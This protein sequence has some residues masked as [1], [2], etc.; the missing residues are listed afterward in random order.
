MRCSHQ[1]LRVMLPFAIGLAVVVTVVATG[2]QAEPQ[3]ER[4]PIRENTRRAP[5]VQA[6]PR[7]ER[8]PINAPQVQI[9]RDVVYATIEQDGGEPIQLTMDVAFPADHGNEPLPVVVLIHGGGFSHGSKRNFDELLQPLARGGY[10]AATIDYR[11][12]GVAPYP[13][14]VHDC[15]AA[16]RFIRDN[17][18]D[19]G[20]DPQRIGALGHSA[21]GHLAAFIAV[22][23]NDEQLAG[24]I[25]TT[26]V[27]DQVRCAVNLSG[28]V[29]FT[30]ADRDEPVLRRIF[31]EWLAQAGTTNE[32]RLMEASVV[33][34]VDSA[35][36]PMLIVH[37]DADRIVSIDQARQLQAKLAEH[38]VEHE[39]VVLEG[40][41]HDVATPE[42]ATA[43]AA[44]LDKHLGGN[45][46]ESMQSFVPEGPAGRAGSRRPIPTDPIQPPGM[47]A[48]SESKSDD[49]DD[50]EP[51]EPSEP[52]PQPD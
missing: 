18:D 14:A 17:A 26:G 39:Y 23:A 6:E 46:A 35:D 48:A 38:G 52:G 22:T 31:D 44:F 42:A 1:Y 43:V 27:G 12:S 10:F 33:T 3:A 21:G 8:R 45:A 47:G 49:D 32:D 36:P 11:L 50:E 16:V 51:T 30:T 13:A 5:T 37:G 24:S 7:G 15:K 34:H 28:L 29:D 19:L 41:G 20:I 25:G 40:V 9:V 2:Q 4:R